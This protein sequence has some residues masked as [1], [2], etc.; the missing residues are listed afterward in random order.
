MTNSKLTHLVL[1]KKNAFRPGLPICHKLWDRIFLSLNTIHLTGFN[2]VC[3]RSSLNLLDGKVSAIVQKLSNR[4]PLNPNE[5]PNCKAYLITVVNILYLTVKKFLLNYKQTLALILTNNVSPFHIKF[6][7]WRP[8]F[9]SYFAHLSF[10]NTE[11][12]LR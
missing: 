9:P 1:R 12:A 3:H 5:H 2:L 7:F 10:E 8:L 4:N 6:T 11:T